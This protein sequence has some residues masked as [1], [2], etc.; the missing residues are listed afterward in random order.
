MGFN[1]YFTFG[2]RREWLESFLEGGFEWFYGCSLGPYQ[3]KALLRYLDDAWIIDAHDF[4]DIG[5]YIAK[6]IK[7]DK[8]TAWQAVW[9]N[10]C[11]NS[12][13]FRWYVNTVKWGE[14]FTKEKLVKKLTREGIRQ[15][16]AQN[17]INSLIN[18]FEN[19]PLGKWFGKRLEKKTYVKEGIETASKELV[20]YMSNMLMV[21]DEDLAHKFLGI[22][23][24]EFLR[25]SALI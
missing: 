17:A 4:T 6:L 23:E 18:T 2:L 25:L 5:E 3:K 1:K 13:L 8:E 22:P 12:D 21:M 19:S 24:E 11:L 10:L 14:T 9:V 16:T 20:W 7:K 15:R